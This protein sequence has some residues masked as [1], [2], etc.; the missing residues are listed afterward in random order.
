MKLK[1]LPLSYW[2]K[3]TNLWWKM[4][5]MAISD[6]T[7]YAKYMLNKIQRINK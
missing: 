4:A 6:I 7:V 5:D 2:S 3:K 1:F